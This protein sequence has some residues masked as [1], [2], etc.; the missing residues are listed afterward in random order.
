MRLVMYDSVAHQAPLFMEFSQQGFWSGL[1]FPTPGEFPDTGIKPVS[2]A[3]P[4]LAGQFFT[5][6]ATWETL[7]KTQDHLLATYIIF[8]KLLDIA[9]G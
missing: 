6:S 2:L 4:A 3:S 5:T 7:C 1:P 9:F 8:G